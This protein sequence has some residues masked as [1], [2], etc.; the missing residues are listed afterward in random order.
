MQRKKKA[1]GYRPDPPRVWQY[2]ISGNYQVL[3]GKT[4]VDNDRLSLHLAAP[5]NWW[6]HVR[7]MP[8][9]H[10]ILK[11]ESDR[12]PDRNILKQAAAIAAYHSKARNG[13]V[14][15]VSATLAKYV[16]KPRGAK[17]GSVQIRKEQILKVR[18][19]LPEAE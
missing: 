16:S 13:G 19:S 3:A 11:A 12:D 9:S 18:P 17:P 8:G 2:T 7:G 14:V 10:V 1:G 5:N 15:S 6:F 4:D